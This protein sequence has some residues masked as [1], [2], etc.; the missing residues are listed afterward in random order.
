MDIS[1]PWTKRSDTG[2]SAGFLR[3]ICPDKD[4]TKR[5]KKSVCYLSWELRT[6]EVKIRVKSNPRCVP[7]ATE[8]KN[9]DKRHLLL[10][11]STRQLAN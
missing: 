9:L 7:F 2:T 3:S 8:E 11:I 6:R 10:A 1:S 4:H 5:A